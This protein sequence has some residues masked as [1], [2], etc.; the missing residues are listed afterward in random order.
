M[1]PVCWRKVNVCIL[2]AKLNIVGQY[3]AD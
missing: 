3:H 2:E 1:C